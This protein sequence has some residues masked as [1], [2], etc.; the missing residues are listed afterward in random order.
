MLYLIKFQLL[1]KSR[2]Q[3][4]KYFFSLYLYGAV[5]KDKIKNFFVFFFLNE[6]LD[7]LY[8]S[9]DNAPPQK[10]C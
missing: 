4:F 8:T 5:M 9:S 1:P 6:K 10:V 3:V 7:F 2:L